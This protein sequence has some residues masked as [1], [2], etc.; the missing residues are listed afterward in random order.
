MPERVALY[1]AIRIDNVAFAAYCHKA[2][3]DV[4]R[5]KGA[6]SLVWCAAGNDDATH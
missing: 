1:N 2:G 3:L 5:E 4:L 6:Q